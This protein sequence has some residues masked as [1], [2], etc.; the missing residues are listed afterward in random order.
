MIP[1]KTILW[2]DASHPSVASHPMYSWA[3]F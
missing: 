3:Y 2:D 1:M